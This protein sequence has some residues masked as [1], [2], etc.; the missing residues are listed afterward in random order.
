MFEDNGEDF[1]CIR[2]QIYVLTSYQILTG[3][4]SAATVELFFS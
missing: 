4:T 2:R 1:S 3:L